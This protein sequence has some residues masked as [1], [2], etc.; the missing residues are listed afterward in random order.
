MTDARDRSGMPPSDDPSWAHYSQTILEF[1]AD[2]SLKLDL[3]KPVAPNAVA[4]LDEQG[5][6]PTYR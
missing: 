4:R 1:F 3:T 5:V 6:G 2:R